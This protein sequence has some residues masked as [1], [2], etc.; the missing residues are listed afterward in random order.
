[1]IR[2]FGW[3]LLLLQQWTT[4]TRDHG[5]AAAAPCRLVARLLV[6]RGM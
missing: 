1:M 4:D 5:C 6:L 2:G 3:W